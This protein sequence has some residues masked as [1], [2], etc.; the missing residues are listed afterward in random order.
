VLLVA[1]T[2]LGISF[3]LLSRWPEGGSNYHSFVIARRMDGREFMYQHVLVDEA[4]AEE[5]VRFEREARQGCFVL[6]RSKHLDS[7]SM[8]RH[9]VGLEVRA[10]TFVCV[11]VK[12]SVL[13]YTI[14]Q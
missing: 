7:A 11:R 5:L 6:A 14:T 10:A 8:S 2:L 3:L 9:C 12:N 13:T 1:V 4:S